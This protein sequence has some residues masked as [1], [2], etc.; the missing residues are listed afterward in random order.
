MLILIYW[1]LQ[2]LSRYQIHIPLT[3]QVWNMFI[4]CIYIYMYYYP[5]KYR[6]HS[7]SINIP[8]I[9]HVPWLTPFKSVCVHGIDTPRQT[10]LAL[11]PCPGSKRRSEVC[12][13]CRAAT[14]NVR[15]SLG[16]PG[17]GDYPCL[18]LAS[19]SKLLCL[20]HLSIIK[21]NTFNS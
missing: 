7:D 2:L 1:Q 9:F 20:A 12:E 11:G 3:I 5:R 19:L 14:C 8:F 21:Y 4:M 18:A 17:C 16:G 15:P 10:S 13:R 6:N